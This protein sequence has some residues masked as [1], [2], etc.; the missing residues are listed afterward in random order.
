M[1]LYHY[2]CIIIAICLGAPLL[3]G[4][5]RHLDDP[6]YL[7]HLLVMSSS[8]FHVTSNLIFYEINYHHIQVIN[9]YLFNI[10]KY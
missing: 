2:W 1:K 4:A 6:A 8:S 10:K 3:Y 7:A 5:S 9:I